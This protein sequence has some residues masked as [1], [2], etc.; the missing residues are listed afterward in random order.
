MA[1]VSS[2]MV[3][4]VFDPLH[5]Q[6]VRMLTRQASSSGRID[7]ARLNSVRQ[8]VAALVQRTFL[9]L[10]LQDG[11][12][13][14]FVEHRGQVIPRSAYF[15]ALWG[16]I[17]Q[18]VAVAVERHAAIMRKYLPADLQQAFSQ[19]YL[20]PNEALSEAEDEPTYDPL[21]LWIGPD[22]KQLSDRIW[23]ITGDMGRKLDQYL[24]DAIA[25]GKPVAYMAQELERFLLPGTAHELVYTPYGNVA[26]EALRLARTEV[27]AAGHRADWLAA[28]QNPF[29]EQYQPVLSPTHTV[30]DE[31]DVNAEGGPYPVGD[32]SH[33]P[34]RHPSCQDSIQ[35]LEAQDPDSVVKSLRAQIADALKRGVKT[36]TDYLNP[37]T[38]RLGEWMLRGRS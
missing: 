10:P 9:G 24:T 23:Q 20:D 21:H 2:V 36:I 4:E 38:T 7:P 37:L 16:L 3:Q 12:L 27:S 11:S 1:Q 6:L 35:W 17:H 8:Q 31:C 30:Y 25:S 34:P 15:T 14:P 29:V 13:H 26:Y 18:A 32:P 33:L 22:G 19:G 28:Q 5:A